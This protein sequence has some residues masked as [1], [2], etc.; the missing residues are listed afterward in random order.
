MSKITDKQKLDYLFKKKQNLG[1]TDLD[2]NNKFQPLFE[3][4]NYILIRDILSQDLPSVSNISE[5]VDLNSLRINES[6][7]YSY[8]VS[9]SLKKDSKN[10]LLKVEQL[11][12]IK[13]PN[14]TNS[15]YCLDTNG[16]NFL[17]PIINSNYGVKDGSTMPDYQL[18]IYS[19]KGL[20][21]FSRGE[22]Y[23]ANEQLR[24]CD[25][26]IDYNTGI[27]LLTD[28]CKDNE[29]GMIDNNNPP[30]I[31]FFKYIGTT[32]AGSG[33]G[34]GLG[35]QWTKNDGDN[36]I[37]YKNGNVLIGLNET[38]NTNS[39]VNYELEISGN[40]YISNNLH[41]KG[42]H[43]IHDDLHVI[44]DI[45]ANTLNISGTADISG[46][47]TVNGISVFQDVSGAD[48]S[49]NN[50]YITGNIYKD[51]EEFSSGAVIEIS[52]NETNVEIDS[53]ESKIFYDA[54]RN[55]FIGGVRQYPDEPYRASNPVIIEPLGYSFFRENM[56]GQPP[57]PSFFFFSITP[58]SIQIN[59][60]NPKQYV[61]GVSN[62]NDPY[63][64]VTNGELSATVNSDSNIY[65]PVVNRIMIQIK[66]KAD[67]SDNPY[68][69]WGTKTS[70]IS[71]GISGL[72]HGRV[73]CS[74]NYPIP[75]IKTGIDPG[76]TGSTSISNG[77]ENKIYELNDF[78]NSI[79]LY[80][81]GSTPENGNL[82]L[83]G[84]NEKRISGNKSDSNSTELSSSNS[85]YEIKLWLENQYNSGSMTESDFN[86]VTLNDTGDGVTP[87]NFSE[88]DPPSTDASLNAIIKFNDIST[89]TN[90]VQNGKTYVELQ[91][92]DPSRSAN[93]KPELNGSIN[94]TGIKFEIA[95]YNDGETPG[96]LVSEIYFNGT[97]SK[98]DNSNL[99]ST[100]ISG[101][102]HT[103]NRLRD[104]DTRYYYVPLDNTKSKKNIQFRIRY[105][106][107]TNAT[108]SLQ[109]ETKTIIIDKPSKPTISQIKMSSSDQIEISIAAMTANNKISNTSSDNNN[110]GVFLRTIDLIAKYEKD[111]GNIEEYVSQ[112]TTLDVDDKNYYHN[113]TQDTTTT[114]I[115]DLS[116]T[117]IATN[118][119]KW[120]F[121]VRVKNNLINEWSVISDSAISNSDIDDTSNN[122]IE[123]TT[124][125]TNNSLTDI[126]FNNLNERNDGI[127]Q[128]NWNH[129]VAGDRGVI[130]GKLKNTTDQNP[131]I[132]DYVV[133]IFRP[134]ITTNQ[135]VKT[136]TNTQNN[137]TSDATNSKLYDDIFS[138]I[139][140]NG[141]SAN[142]A[143]SGNTNDTEKEIK[144]LVKQRNEYVTNQKDVSGSIFYKLGAPNVP[145]T[146]TNT[147]AINSTG[148]NTITLK[149]TK[150]TT[151]G[152]QTREL[153][154]SELPTSLS[155]KEVGVINYR[156]DISANA[157]ESK[158]PY[159]RL[160]GGKFTSAPTAPQT[161]TNINISDVSEANTYLVDSD[162]I[163]DKSDIWS[164]S[165]GTVGDVLVF[166]ET[167][168]TFN[169]W[170]KNI[171][172]IESASS[173]TITLNTGLPPSINSQLTL[174]TI[175]INATYDDVKGLTN[176]TYSNK[177]FL[178]ESNVDTTPTTF[179]LYE[180]TKATDFPSFNS[181]AVHR[182][183]K[184]KF[185]DFLVDNDT[186]KNPSQYVKLTSHLHDKK[187]RQFRI[188][189]NTTE[190]YTFG[191]DS[192]FNIINDTTPNTA[193][194]GML[195]I[196]STNVKDE[197]N[198]SPQ[199]PNNKGY[200]WKETMEYT[201][202]IDNTKS[203]LYKNPI[204]L[205]FKVRYN[206]QLSSNTNWTSSS[207]NTDTHVDAVERVIFQN[208]E[209]NTDNN[210][211]YFDKL[212]SL[213]SAA[214]K[215]AG[216]NMIS[217][218]TTNKI[219][220][221]PNLYIISSSYS[222][223]IS[224]NY[225]LT[226]FSEYY[227]LDP[228]VNFVEH[229]LKSNSGSNV[230]I[231]EIQPRSWNSKSNCVRTANEW[232]ITNL[233]ITNESATNVSDVDLGSSSETGSDADVR[234]ELN[235]KN[236]FSGNNFS[237]G[238]AHSSVF[239]FIYDKN[240][241]DVYNSLG[242]TLKKAK[243][244]TS[245][246]S[247]EP[248]DYD[249]SG[250]ITD[251]NQLN[252]WNGWFYSKSGWISSTGISTT[253]CSNYGLTAGDAGDVMFQ[254]NDDDYKFV[255]FEYSYTAVSGYTPF[256]GFVVFGDNADFEL[257]DIAGGVYGG[258]TDI[259]L[260]LFIQSYNMNSH[261]YLNIGEYTSTTFGSAA[262][263]N[264][265]GYS[266][267]GLGKVPYTS[268]S[269]DTNWS[270]GGSLI[271]TSGNG[272][273]GTASSTDYTSRPSS[274]NLKR[275]MNFIYNKVG[276]YNSTSNG[277]IFKHYLCIG[278]KNSINRKVK[279]PDLYIYA[280]ATTVKKL[281]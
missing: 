82:S 237:V 91:I 64:D 280:G 50:I 126:S 54:S 3:N 163:I 148:N 272:G 204:K 178:L 107:A 72:E 25:Y 116:N 264:I 59:W 106:N 60:T 53:N 152:F 73:V 211:I 44:D 101:G 245:T 26:I 186:D 76:F 261:Y 230:S 181:S 271:P 258:K 197:Y 150:N 23:L 88:A 96:F 161:I 127:I 65:F 225:N 8:N 110:N 36:S 165:T 184:N 79:I 276:N 198:D 85:G 189:N 84:D 46:N 87:I 55:L 194:D 155:N 246:D 168:Y 20:D 75:P 183:N 12:L 177:G 281:S 215:D 10:I 167:S 216:T 95:Y 99:S 239:R 243:Q 214:K 176:Y 104:N 100:D 208:T 201:I 111:N 81:T 77:R 28:N 132:K 263:G 157:P 22:S 51:G 233:I 187:L 145:D 262:G 158:S 256:G 62:I 210:V 133:S 120:A 199:D 279:K 6:N 118:S 129:P 265:T 125:S 228:N 144:V 173:R 179:T 260:Y 156:V 45:S 248:G 274:S 229:T 224:L 147:S 146:D 33:S 41:V 241:V 38:N 232:T 242:T 123:I 93:D 212:T 257:S 191:S 160:A 206:D 162:G 124:V 174:S 185:N 268:S 217:Y 29:G 92:K 30:Y 39:N 1:F 170:S 114:Y 71:S 213:P 63:D 244:I 180:I 221:I 128:L 182:I 270:S 164:D 18:E 235:L 207:L 196:T 231:S 5:T 266:G 43:I 259:K 74:K 247:S 226:N 275:T 219:N 97:S 169:I 220:G 13:V 80:S 42:D 94:L 255:I 70:P 166:P 238:S 269:D 200:W 122:A 78:A 205:T 234:L 172:N 121:Q 159:Y 134:D 203:T 175:P 109:T 48:A 52:G 130:T 267:S 103:F 142:G 108:L 151:T 56:E 277:N 202:A 154:N 140:Q 11:K 273:W 131:T 32:G 227:G 89:A 240:S 34:T 21:R 37:Y 15:W 105:K 252:M 209:N 4:R 66:D 192:S 254:G 222:Y 135:I 117:I 83:T 195:A 137:R 67:N 171:F 16:D 17:T 139:D 35:G 7:F 90:G 253:N 278:I 57:A 138:I 113:N 40:V 136:F 249:A 24:S 102:F 115:F 86:V 218:T 188:L 193:L 236:T 98:N 119:L 27:L 69:Y 9:S 153:V 251:E 223:D 141:S 47:L 19:K 149:W 14:T 112:I 58:S 61:S 250:N 49:F 2:A 68:R 190:I 31:T 143:G